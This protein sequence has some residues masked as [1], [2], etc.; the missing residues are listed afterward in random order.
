[1][2]HEHRVLP[3]V[4]CDLHVLVLGFHNLELAGF[5]SSWAHFGLLSSN[6]EHRFF[7]LHSFW[8]EV[9]KVLD[10]C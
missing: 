6:Q 5:G 3:G 8:P 7:N 4:L 1:M 9:F 2:R 10:C